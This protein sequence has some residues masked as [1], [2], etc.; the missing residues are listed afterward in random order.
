MVETRW[1]RHVLFPDILGVFWFNLSFVKHSK[2]S[3]T[4]AE[5]PLS[6]SQ[7]G[8]HLSI[9]RK[10]NPRVLHGQVIHHQKIATSP[11]K[12]YCVC[13]CCCPDVLQRFR[14]NLASVA[15]VSVTGKLIIRDLCAVKVW[16]VPVVG[17]IV[18]RRLVEP[19]FLSGHRMMYEDIPSLP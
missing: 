10:P 11:L 15:I 19:D 2:C 12:P 1:T 16:H 3:F 6:G 9:A 18:R 4:K 8:E 17:A 14:F 5:A 7:I 13:P